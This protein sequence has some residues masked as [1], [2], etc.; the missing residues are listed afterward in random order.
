MTRAGGH[1]L[2]GDFRHQVTIQQPTNGAAD[3]IGGYRKTLTTLG[4]VWAWVQPGKA[5][6]KHVAGGLRQEETIT[7]TIRYPAFT[8]DDTCRVLWSGKT[9]YVQGVQMP[10]AVTKALILTCCEG[11]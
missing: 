5:V 11:E 3:G 10:D 2:P 7:V 6:E 9:W 8:V 1:Y 4:T